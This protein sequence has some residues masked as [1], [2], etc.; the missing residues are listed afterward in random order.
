MAQYEQDQ[1]N[2][3]PQDD[4]YKIKLSCGFKDGSTH[5]LNISPLQL[6]KIK[7]VLK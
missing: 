5:V 3:L 4:F 1:I 6:K 7:G 2:S